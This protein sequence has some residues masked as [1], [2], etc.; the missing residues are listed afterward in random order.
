LLWKLVWEITLSGFFG[1]PFFTFTL[2]FPPFFLRF[3][4]VFGFSQSYFHEF[5][6]VISTAFLLWNLLWEFTDFHSL[7]FNLFYDSRLYPLIGIKK[8]CII[9]YTAGPAEE[10][11]KHASG[12][13]RGRGELQ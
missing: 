4:S 6:I 5:L 10:P 8:Q 3:S 9:K 11:K 2:D 7:F 1:I 13:G 12:S